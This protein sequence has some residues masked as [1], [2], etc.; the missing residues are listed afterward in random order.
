MRS[1]T[2]AS[3]QSNASRMPR[4]L[5]VSRACNDKSHSQGGRFQRPAVMRG[6]PTQDGGVSRLGPVHAIGMGRPIANER[7]P[8]HAARAASAARLDSVNK[9]LMSLHCDRTSPAPKKPCTEVSACRRSC[10]GAVMRIPTSDSDS[11]AASWR[12]PTTTLQG[13]QPARPFK[14]PYDQRHKAQA[15]ARVR[16]SAV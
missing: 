2:C 11:E 3:H 9:C 12:R 5:T 13:S 6:E 4:Q 16:F 8:I 14:F 1:I 10:A 7:C 15:Y